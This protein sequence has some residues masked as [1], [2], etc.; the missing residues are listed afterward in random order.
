M[1]KQLRAYHFKND[2]PGLDDLRKLTSAYPAREC[3]N[4]ETQHFGFKP[5]EGRENTD[6]EFVLSLNSGRMVYVELL[7]MRR[8]VPAEAVKRETR[9]RAKAQE[10]R[11]GGEPLPKAEIKVIKDQVYGELLGRALQ[12]ESV[13]PILI[14]VDSN[15]VWF[16]AASDGAVS[17]AFSMLRNGGVNIE[18]ESIWPEIDLT[19]WMA[20]W[21]VGESELPAQFFAGGRVKACDPLEIKATVTIA[22]EELNQP[23]IIEMIKKRTITELEL[24]SPSICLTLSHN[25][26]LKGIKVHIEADAD[27][28]LVHRY[29]FW[30]LEIERAVQ[31][32]SNAVN[33]ADH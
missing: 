6:E 21:V 29:S 27:D 18:S 15:Q 12:K 25:K 3:R 4:Q 26:S 16:G 10:D 9:K 22:N 20:G 11:Q 24:E 32:I 23:D 33:P 5:F 1:F 28:D 13:I 31:A 2:V 8:I 30:A 14:Q 19:A 7:K 17:D